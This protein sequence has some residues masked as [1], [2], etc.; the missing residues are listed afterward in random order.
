MSCCLFLIALRC[1]EPG[2]QVPQGQGL[3]ELQRCSDS[4]VLQAFLRVSGFQGF[5]MRKKATKKKRNRRETKARTVWRKAVGPVAVV[6]LDPQT[7]NTKNLNSDLQRAFVLS[8]ACLLTVPSPPPD[9]LWKRPSFWDPECQVPRCSSPT[10]KNIKKKTPKCQKKTGPKVNGQ[11]GS[12]G[13]STSA[14]QE[15]KCRFSL[16]FSVFEFLVEWIPGRSQ[17]CQGVQMNFRSV[18]SQL[19]RA[20]QRHGHSRLALEA[21]VVV[22]E[23][24]GD[25]QRPGGVK[26]ALRVSLCLSRRRLRLHHPCFLASVDVAASWTLLATV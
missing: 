5:R 10:E 17:P 8:I 14:V 26:S 12:R 11:S 9:P 25:R 1:D 21:D 19:F 13:P 6:V 2:L 7:V 16:R 15:F 22:C 4:G 20:G 3:Q 23:A 18:N 24:R